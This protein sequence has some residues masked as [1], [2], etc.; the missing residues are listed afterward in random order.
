MGQALALL[1]EQVEVTKEEVQEAEVVV[2]AAVVWVGQLGA[3][4]F[5][6]LQALEILC[7][8]G[9]VEASTVG[10]TGEEMCGTEGPQVAN[11]VGAC[12]VL[13]LDSIYV[14]FCD[15]GARGKRTVLL[16]TACRNWWRCCRT[17]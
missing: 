4:V 1:R 7:R 17:A 11:G 6:Q 8:R 12:L 16:G 5:R 15:W 14:F 13:C 2:A 3:W 9:S 10:T